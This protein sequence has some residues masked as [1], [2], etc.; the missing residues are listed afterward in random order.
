M[1]GDF[2]TSQYEKNYTTAMHS[3]SNI[4]LRAAIWNERQLDYHKFPGRHNISNRI[5]IH[6]TLQ[7]DVRCHYSNFRWC[8]SWFSIPLSVPSVLSYIPKLTK[9]YSIHLP[10]I[11]LLLS[12]SNNIDCCTCGI[13]CNVQLNPSRVQSP[14]G[15]GASY[16][17]GEGPLH[18][19][20]DS[21][22]EVAQL[23]MFNQSRGSEK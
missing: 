14:W 18:L 17:A 4:A 22:R 20:H 2:F 6:F 19:A 11:Y 8:T 10:F 23:M 15:W 13:G 3:H 16:K 7:Q 9:N 12:M 1:K 21:N 5:V